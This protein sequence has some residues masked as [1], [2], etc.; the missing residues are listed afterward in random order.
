MAFSKAYNLAIFTL[1]PLYF[2]N[3]S[4]KPLEKHSK[5]AIGANKKYPDE[6][7]FPILIYVKE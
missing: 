6:K 2:A 1:L 5:S 4:L 7:I 3:F